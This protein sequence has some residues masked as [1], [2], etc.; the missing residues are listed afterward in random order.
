M[1]DPVISNY[2]YGFVVLLLSWL[3]LIISFTAAEKL[4]TGFIG[5]LHTDMKMQL[6][7]CK[8]LQVSSTYLQKFLVNYIQPLDIKLSV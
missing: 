8:L 4:F 7:M 5:Y 3:T 1:L 2:F 6:T